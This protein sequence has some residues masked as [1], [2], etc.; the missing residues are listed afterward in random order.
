VREG[1][2]T[3]ASAD[4]AG[5]LKVIDTGVRRT[6]RRGEWARRLEYGSQWYI[7]RRTNPGEDVTIGVT[8][9]YVKEV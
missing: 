5:V 1:A 8:V 7:H 2:P 4:A 3:A 9:G 6:I